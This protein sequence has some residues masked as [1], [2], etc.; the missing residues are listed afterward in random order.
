MISTETPTPISRA[1]LLLGFCIS[2]TNQPFP[3]DAFVKNGTCQVSNVSWEQQW[4][5]VSANETYYVPVIT[6]QWRN[7]TDTSGR[8]SSYRGLI[9]NLLY[10]NDMKVRAICLSQETFS[11]WKRGHKAG[12][13][14]SYRNF[15]RPFLIVDKMTA[16]SIVSYLAFKQRLIS[17]W[18]TT[19]LHWRWADL[20]LAGLY[21]I[22][23]WG[24]NSIF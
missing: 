9:I 5:E 20:R 14:N 11:A 21:C 8:Y 6:V 23:M 12:D 2:Q 24:L 15:R 4:C 10:R 7:Y 19:C 17:N 18:S 22:G 1:T 13:G 16:W 3:S